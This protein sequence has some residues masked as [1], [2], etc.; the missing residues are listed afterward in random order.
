M[1][2][3][4]DNL[5][6]LLVGIG[7]L[8]GVGALFA[9]A[10]ISTRKRDAALRTD[11]AG[12]GYAPLDNHD[13]QVMQR[14]ESVF[15]ATLD[16]RQVMSVRNVYHKREAGADLYVMDIEVSAANE[17]RGGGK[18][19]GRRMVM[20]TADDLSLPR[21]HLYPTL[22]DAGAHAI[23]A[24]VVGLR[25][26]QILQFANLLEA[27]VSEHPDFRRRFKLMTDDPQGVQDY[28]TGSRLS[29]L[30]GMEP[31]YG[32]DAV[33]NTLFVNEYFPTQGVTQDQ[34]VVRTV[35]AA[36]S[37]HRIFRTDE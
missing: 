1:T 32:I 14:V 20:L 23:A 12:M 30:M 19:I 9:W 6:G 7:C 3:D 28:L 24:P 13:P 8:G 31:Q 17:R 5:C 18:V 16:P 37:A 22:A 26:N 27:D 33:G 21:M 25:V 2:I 4:L 29:G 35:Q 34:Q 36:Q 11:M 10:V 15:R